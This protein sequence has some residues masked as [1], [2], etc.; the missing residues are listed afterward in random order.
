MM[1]KIFLSY[2]IL[3]MTLPMMAQQPAGKA[4]PPDRAKIVM[5]AK[6]V[7]E[8]AKYCT[9]VTLGED[10]H[11]QARIVDPFAPDDGLSVWIGTN[12]VT[13]KIAQIKKDPR[14]TLVYFDPAGMSYVTLLGKAVIVDDPAEKAKH[15]KDAWTSLYK[16]KNRG[17]D[18]ILIRVTALRLEIIS[19][20]D[21]LAND[22][23]TWR[24]VVLDLAQR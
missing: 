5:A 18:F 19:F 17:P 13:R 4:A 22:P 20:A 24:P 7:M 10:G 23:Q 15:W 11:P 16:D 2:G 21:G 9:L 1:K 8:K 12:P 6:R 3:A 14:V